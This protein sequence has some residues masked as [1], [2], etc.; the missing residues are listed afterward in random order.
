MVILDLILQFFKNDNLICLIEYD[1]IQHFEHREFLMT[2][3]EYFNLKRNDELKNLYCK[4]NNIILLRIKY[5]DFNKIEK[6]LLDYLSQ[7][8]LIQLIV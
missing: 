1:G 3:E 4:N 5:T 8:N 7:F 6:I 2:K